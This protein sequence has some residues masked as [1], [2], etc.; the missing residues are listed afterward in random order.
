MAQQKKQVTEEKGI[1]SQ[2]QEGTRRGRA[3]VMEERVSKESSKQ[4][5]KKESEFGTCHICKAPTP[6]HNH[7]G[8]VRSF[9]VPYLPLSL[10]LLTLERRRKKWPGPT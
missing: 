2:P 9:Y 7:I 3:L 1:K 10:A 5:T 4:S 8:Q 6:D